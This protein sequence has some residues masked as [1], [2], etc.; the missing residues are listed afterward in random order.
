M[1]TSHR[2][3]ARHNLGQAPA[4]L[5]RGSLEFEGSA[6]SGGPTPAWQLHNEGPAA[7]AAQAG[8]SGQQA[9]EVEAVVVTAA[10]GVVVLRPL[11]SGAPQQARQLQR[12]LGQHPLTAPLSGVSHSVYRGSRVEPHTGR[13]EG[14][15]YRHAATASADS[16][17][18]SPLEAPG[19]PR[20]ADEQAQQAQQQQGAQ[21]MSLDEVQPAGGGAV[22]GE[23]QH[24]QHTE[25]RQQDLVLDGDLL[26]L[27]PA[28]PDSVQQQLLSLLG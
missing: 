3:T 10:G 22:A 2:T 28:L 11:R 9:G 20:P 26:G 18:D 27:L 19:S 13:R 5:L 14:L 1:E 7:G 21:R 4:K 15:L 16:V 24:A 8:G 23:P 12:A 17:L 25:Q 6:A